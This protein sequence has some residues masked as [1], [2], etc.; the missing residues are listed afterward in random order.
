MQRTPAAPLTRD[1]RCEMKFRIGICIVLHVAIVLTG[2]WLSDYAI[3]N[4]KLYGKAHAFEDAGDVELYWKCHDHS[5]QYWYDRSERATWG[6]LGLALAS[7]ALVRFARSFESK[8]RRLFLLFPAA[9]VAILIFTMI[10]AGVR[11]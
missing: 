2:L 5:P 7:G 4:H 3:K 8:R 1:V 10:I 9:C 6:L 11:Y